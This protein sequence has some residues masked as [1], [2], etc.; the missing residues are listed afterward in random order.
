MN[1]K[2]ILVLTSRFPYPV[3]GGDRL[4]IFQICKELSKSYDITL[5]T[6]CENRKEMKYVVPNDKVFNNIE[7]VY[8]PKWQSFL[9]CLPALISK[10]PLQ[11]AYYSSANF[12]KLVD[13]MTLEH[14][15][16][17]AHLV[18]T[19]EYIREKKTKKILEMTDAISMNYERFSKIKNKSGLMG[20]VYTVEKDRL[21]LYEKRIAKY[22][23]HNILV[24]KVDKD[25]LFREDKELL[26]KVSVCSNGVDLEKFPYQFSSGSK[27]ITFIGNMHSA[28]NMDAV[29]WFIINVL[30]LL[31]A[32]KEFTLKVIGRIKEN[33]RLKLEKYAGVTTTGEVENVVEYARGSFAAV[34][35]VRLAAGV[36]NKILEY[37]ALGVP[38]VTTTTGL[39]GLQ[40]K[41]NHDLIIADSAIAT[42]NA[43]LK[44]HLDENYAEKISKNAFRYVGEVHSW[45][46]SLK[47]LKTEIHKLVF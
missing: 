3:V 35:P 34:C 10:K 17:L 32:N 18:R 9:N 42:C 2:T 14:D 33:D 29:L 6:F 44:L 36:Q 15:L 1:R 37:M 31:R 21:Y 8:L 43:L 25:F 30:P 20:F 45:S 27:V 26:S 40:A 16:V 39:E 46:S 11:V 13:K 12:Q 41:P 4:R 5:L 28:Q 19:A 7:R 24:S 23:D 47:K 38:I 22:F